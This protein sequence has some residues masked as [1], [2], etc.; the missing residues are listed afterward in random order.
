VGFGVGIV[1]IFIDTP[2]G[3]RSRKENKAKP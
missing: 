3:G 1:R 2:N